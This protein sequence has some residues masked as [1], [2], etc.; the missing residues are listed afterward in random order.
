MLLRETKEK[1]IIKKLSF[2]C[3]SLLSGFSNGIM[4]R[5]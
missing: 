1:S 5:N 4:M 2:A 3:E